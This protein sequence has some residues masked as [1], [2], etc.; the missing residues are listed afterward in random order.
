MYETERLLVRNFMP[1]DAEQCM[2]SWG[3]DKKLGRYIISYPMQDISQMR[4]FVEIMSKQENAW[5]IV[6][7][8]SKCIV[9]YI[10][11]DI[12]YESLKIGELGYVI[13]EKYQGNGYSYEAIKKI[14]HNY[15]EVKNLYLVEAKYNESNIGSGKILNKLGFKKEA[16]LRGRRID[17]IS[18]ERNNM[19]ICSITKDEFEQ[20]K[21]DWY[22]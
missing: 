20:K 19:V 11:I 6:E 14:L 4:D 10:T 13:G 21:S 12:T 8:K 7:K 16:I 5:V 3:K 22:N 2:E 9:G 17:G 15:F 1:E 18:K